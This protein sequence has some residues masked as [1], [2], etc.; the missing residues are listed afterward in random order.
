MF[1]VRLGSL[2]TFLPLGLD[3]Y[4]DHLNLIKQTGFILFLLPVNIFFI[5]WFQTRLIK[6]AGGYS[7]QS[8]YVYSSLLV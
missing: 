4:E 2:F 3:G 7:T 6:L 8:L 5:A 1:V